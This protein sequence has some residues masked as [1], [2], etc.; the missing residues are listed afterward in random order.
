MK[1]LRILFWLIALAGGLFSLFVLFFNNKTVEQLPSVF[2]SGI[3]LKVIAGS[4]LK[5]IE[6]M[7]TTIK[8]KTG[9]QLQIDYLGTLDGAEKI[10]S[11]QDP[12]DLAWFSHAKYLSLLQA[13]KKLI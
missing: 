11:Q 3:T 1:L 4:E 8:A 12:Y 13:D 5:D 9:V 7:L 6:P 10:V 2:N